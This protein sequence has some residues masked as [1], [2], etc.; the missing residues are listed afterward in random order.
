MTFLVA[1]ALLLVA[2]G[3]TAV[4]LTRDPKA[5]AVVLSIYG[6]LLTVMFVVLQAPDVAMAQLAVG[7]VVLPLLVVL[8]IARSGK[9]E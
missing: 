1:A 4:V 6:L 9:R 8:T 7:T 3:G 2:F 5:Q